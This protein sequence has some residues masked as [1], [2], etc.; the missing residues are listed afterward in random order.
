MKEKDKE[1]RDDQY[2]R[3]IKRWKGGRK[4]REI[5]QGLHYI[6]RKITNEGNRKKIR[7]RSIQESDKWNERK[8]KGKEREETSLT[9]LYLEKNKMIKK[10]QRK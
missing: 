3:G 10:I 1:S 7:R 9:L 8:R 5:E 4:E 6:L 2:K